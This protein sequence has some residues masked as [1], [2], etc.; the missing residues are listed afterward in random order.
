MQRIIFLGI[1]LLFPLFAFALAPVT[2]SQSQPGSASSYSA[3][4]TSTLIYTLTNN[5]PKNLPIVANLSTGLTRTTVANDCIN[6]MS[7]GP[8]TCNIGI[9]ITPLT[10]QIAST[11]SQRL[12]INYQARLPLTSTMSYSV[13]APYA[14]VT[15]FTD[16]RVINKCELNITD[17]KFIPGTCVQANPVT[18]SLAF[19]RLMVGNVGGQQYVYAA[20][21]TYNPT[22]Y[23]NQCF[24]ES[25]GSFSRCSRIP[26]TYSGW[27]PFDI[28]FATV[29][30]QQYAYIAD[31]T[32]YSVDRCILDTT[33]GSFSSCPAPI[34][35]TQFGQPYGVAFATTSRGIQYAYVA[36]AGD[37]TAP[38]PFPSTVYRCTLSNGDIAYPCETAVQSPAPNPFQTPYAIAFATSSGA[39]YAYVADN[40]PDPGNAPYGNVYKCTLTEDGHLSSCLPTPTSSA[41]TWNPEYIAFKTIGGIQ[42]A[43]VASDL[44][45]S[46]DM[47]RCKVN[48]G[49]GNFDSSSCTT[50]PSSG[51]IPW[52]GAPIGIAIPN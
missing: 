7:A 1:C 46:G 48:D 20:D 14:Y 16:L 52:T 13:A 25:N 10:S 45:G 23:V 29:D 37:P 40:G 41:P 6:T 38:T 5:V 26:I 17:G 12:Q 22:P 35:T 3:G 21:R 34:N 28:T 42:Y 11:I 51:T 39:Q 24:L 50:T 8:S 4:V 19:F 2:L 33:T 27:E 47:Y 49:D 43:Y 30:G 31:I 18:T 32:N 36:D 15:S 9:S 44:A